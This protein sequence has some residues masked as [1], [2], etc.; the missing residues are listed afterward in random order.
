MQ[1]H[2]RIRVTEKMNLYFTY[3]GR[4]PVG[5]TA[6]LNTLAN[7]TIPRPRGSRIIIDATYEIHPWERLRAVP[8]NVQR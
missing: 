2:T 6:G 7:S 5:L 8:L 1:L 4:R 3:V